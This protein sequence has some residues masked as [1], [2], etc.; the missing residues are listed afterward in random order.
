MLSE[1]PRTKS[2]G[3]YIALHSFEPSICC[4]GYSL[5][6]C[7]PRRP[8][9]T[10]TVISPPL[11]IYASLIS[12]STSWSVLLP[13]HLMLHTSMSSC[14]K[15]ANCRCLTVIQASSDKLL[16]TL[17]LLVAA[18][19]FVYYTSWA[20]LTVSEGSCV[21]RQVHGSYLCAQDRSSSQTSCFM[22]YRAPSYSRRVCR[23]LTLSAVPTPRPSSAIFL[24]RPRM[25]CPLTRISPYSRYHWRRSVHRAG[26][27]QGSQEEAGKGGN[28]ERLDDAWGEEYG[29]GRIELC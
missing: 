11:P 1:N 20:L 5:E 3:F 4:P 13:N 21:A 10:S 6:T 25:G 23:R 14:T 24:P 19:V 2:E 18:F 22:F 26:H 7:D 17:M 29:Q 27:A 12:L 28:Q 8:S 16:G 9:T 15:S